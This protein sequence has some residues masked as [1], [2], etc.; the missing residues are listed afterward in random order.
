M[1][2]WFLFSQLLDPPECGNGFVEQG[3]ECDCGSQMVGSEIISHRF[4]LKKMQLRVYF[5]KACH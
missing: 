5:I 3:E 4:P 2:H 1:T